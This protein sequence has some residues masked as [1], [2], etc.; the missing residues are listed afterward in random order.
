MLNYF[1]DI[2]PSKKRLYLIIYT[3]ADLLFFNQDI[4]DKI[5]FKDKNKVTKPPEFFNAKAVAQT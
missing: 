4:I 3:P 5:G 2:L 1:V